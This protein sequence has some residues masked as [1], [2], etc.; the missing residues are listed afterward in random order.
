[1]DELSDEDGLILGA[2]GH[3]V[4]ESRAA[5]VHDPRARPTNAIEASGPCGAVLLWGAGQARRIASSA[6]LVRKPL[7]DVSAEGV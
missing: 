5:I 3:I 4:L 7:R 2:L 6:A 1:M